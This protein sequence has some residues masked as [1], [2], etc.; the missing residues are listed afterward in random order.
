MSTT[1]I[2]SNPFADPAAS[3]STVN[4]SQLGSEDATL[5]VGRNASLT[6][7]TD[8]LIVLGKLCAPFGKTILK[9]A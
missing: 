5:P 7:G 2:S 4:T 3:S 9:A 6:L 1:D 8:S